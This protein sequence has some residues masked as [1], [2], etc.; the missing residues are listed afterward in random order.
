MTY[1]IAIDG[2]AGAGKSTIA[3][4]VAKK[5]SFVY[6]DTG[7]LYRALA[8]YFLE[9]GMDS[10][11][12]EEIEAACDQ[13]EVSIQYENGQQQVLLN[14]ENVN[15]KIR[16]EEV[17]NVASMTSGYPKVRQKLLD[18]QRQIARESDVVMDG[19]DIGTFILPNAQLKIF[20]TASVDT[21]AQRRFDQLK[22]KGVLAS[23]EKIKEDI[24]AR[25]ERDINKAISPLKQAEDGIFM[26]S[27]NMTIEEVVDKI[28]TLYK[29]GKE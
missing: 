23:L 11:N 19:R 5:L 2:P 4:N 10:Q 22:N 28:I 1:N 20:L 15:S 18:L 24:R 7:A 12:Q 16:T 3:K 6:V 8:L 27:S 25:D 21:R 29:N 26:D 9:K 13:V 14:K 17:G